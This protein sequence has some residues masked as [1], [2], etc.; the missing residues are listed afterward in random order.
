MGRDNFF[1]QANIVVGCQR[2]DWK[3]VYV[4]GIYATTRQ[5]TLFA[6][7]KK[8]EAKSKEAHHHHRMDLFFFFRHH[9]LGGSKNDDVAMILIISI[10]AKVLVVVFS[11]SDCCGLSD[12]GTEE[13]A[14]LRLS[15]RSVCVHNKRILSL[16]H[17]HTRKRI[18]FSYGRLH[19]RSL[20]KTKRSN[21]AT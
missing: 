20:S 4:D 5:S 11:A 7:R 15:C 19:T 21:K 1:W 13:D 8:Q 18:N 12:D 14:N 17:S 6:H 10:P 3:A 9:Q 2:W 16:S